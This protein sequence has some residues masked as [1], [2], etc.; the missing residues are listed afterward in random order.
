MN[1]DLYYYMDAFN[2]EDA[3]DGAWW[4]ILENAVTFFNAENETS[5]DPFE[6][7]HAYI[8]RSSEEK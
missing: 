5:Y 2:D 8:T 4:A 1:D 6:M 3:P 7:V